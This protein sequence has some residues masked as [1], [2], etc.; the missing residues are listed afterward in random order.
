[1]T[2]VLISGASVAGPTL[3]WWLTR[4]GYSVTLVERTP[5]LRP[6]G[7]A[8]DIRGVALEVV[9]R[10]GLL[11]AI[12]QKR[13]RMQGASALD[14]EG[15]E[16]WRTNERSFTS[17]RFDSGDLEILRDDLVPILYEA[18]RATGE[19][20]FDNTI[21]GIQQ[22]EDS[23]TVEFE[24]GAARRFGLVVGAA[25]IYSKTRGLVFGP[26]E[27]FLRHLEIYVAIF[28]VPNTL[29]LQD[30]QIAISGERSRALICPARDNSELRVFAGFGSPLLDR[31]MGVAQQKALVLEQCSEL[32]WDMPRLFAA[33]QDAP[34]FYLGPMAQIHMPAWSEGRVTLVGDAGYCPS[35]MSGQGTSLAL[36]GAYVLAEE[37]ARN[38]N[39]HT[40][41][42]AR[43]EARMRP[44]VDINQALALR[45]RGDDAEGD[46]AIDEAKNAI[47]L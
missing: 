3:A 4:H 35:P 15:K 45:D 29:G 9:S 47:A 11:P 13:T 30:R 28:T 36:V 25:G 16:V 37:L 24:S 43:Y 21:A 22:S 26:A 34:I 44:F 33:M 14:R 7:Q 10:M 2:T 8:I 18:T 17:G 40:A 39:D 1:M 20:I 38:R 23:V 32:G 5:G 46:K 12:E 31:D 6:G 42:F 27:R 41:A 19:Y